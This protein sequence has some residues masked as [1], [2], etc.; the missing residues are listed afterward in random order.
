VVLEI[1][2]NQPRNTWEKGIVVKCFPGKD[3]IVRV[4]EIRRANGNIYKR[5]V[6]KLCVLD[7]HREE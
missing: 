2:D 4:V 1:S 7:V 3:G 6:H 5:P